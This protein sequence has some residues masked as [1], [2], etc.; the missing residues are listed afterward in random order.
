MAGPVLGQL[1]KFES[2]INDHYQPELDRMKVD[3]RVKSTKSEDPIVTQLKVTEI[4]QHLATLDS[5][6]VLEILELAINQNEHT[7]V[8][9][10]IDAPVVFGSFGIAQGA[11]DIMREDANERSNPALSAAI[12]RSSDLLQSLRSAI[13][14]SRN[15]VM[16]SAGLAV[17]DPLAAIAKEF[18]I[19]QA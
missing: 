16:E 13:T 4:R 5:K 2:D 10:I 19:S 3:L 8:S 17:K 15:S 14:T 7:T 12:K 9:A 18:A 1:A 6:A 11:L